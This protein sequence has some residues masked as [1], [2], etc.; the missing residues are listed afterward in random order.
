MRETKLV[1][2]SSHPLSFKILLKYEKVSPYIFVLL[3]IL[4]VMPIVL[5]FTLCPLFAEPR[6]GKAQA[7]SL[8]GDSRSCRN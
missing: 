7:K 5:L 2:F 6:V 1:L 8:E 4:F 3:F